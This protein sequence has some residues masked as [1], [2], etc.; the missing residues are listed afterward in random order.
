MSSH[1]DA[2]GKDHATAASAAQADSI[3]NIEKHAK[4]Q[5]VTTAVTAAATTATA[6]YAKKQAEEA[7][8][9]ATYAEEQA[10]QAKKQTAILEDKAEY[11][12]LLSFLDN[13]TDTS[14]WK[15]I[16]P[17]VADE[18]ENAANIICVNKLSRL[19]NTDQRFKDIK[20]T[21]KKINEN[22]KAIPEI[23][24]KCESLISDLEKIPNI[25]IE[26]E[27]KDTKIPWIYRAASSSKL[28]LLGLIPM[29][30]LFLLI[31]FSGQ[32]DN[33]TR[34]T[35]KATA[36]A[37]TMTLMFGWV[38]FVIGYVSRRNISKI[39][40]L[41][42]KIAQL[43]SEYKTRTE[44]ALRLYKTTDLSKLMSDNGWKIT[45]QECFECIC[46]L[47]DKWQSKIPPRYRVQ[48][49]TEITKNE[50]RSILEKTHDFVELN[51][52]H[53]LAVSEHD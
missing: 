49:N 10:N 32:P 7:E 50:I 12:R 2:K 40:D 29:F 9:T 26:D 41:K 43:E 19:A 4:L 28:N 20:E 11:E 1:F 38:P 14:K 8:K 52:I 39:T 3:Y 51:A 33:S 23:K 15:T 21:V 37:S 34:S 25:K 27:I 48:L 24:S 53:A 18:I 45:Q 47:T 44:N 31:G 13:E 35:L 6:I 36:G 17:F 42:S 22:D 16:Y 5:T 46:N 30:F